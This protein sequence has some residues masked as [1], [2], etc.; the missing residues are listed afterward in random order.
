MKFNDQKNYFAHLKNA[1]KKEVNL[2]LIVVADDYERSQMIQFS[3]QFFLGDNFEC[4]R[5]DAMDTSYLKISQEADSISLF[6]NSSLIVIDNI[7]KLKDLAKFTHFV[8]KFKNTY[9]LLA[10]PSIKGIELL[11]KKVAKYGIVLNLSKEKP[12]DRNARIEKMLFL[13]AKKK[14]INL[15]QNAHEELIKRVGHNFALLDQELNKLI[16]FKYDTKEIKVEDVKQIVEGVSEVSI[17]QLAEQL[18]FEKKYPSNLVIDISSTNQFISALRYQLQQGFKM[19]SHLK[20]EITS[21]KLK[22][23]FPKLWPKQFEMRKSQVQKLSFSYFQNGLS[24]LHDIELN[25]RDSKSS[26]NA[27]LTLFIARLCHERC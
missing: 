1:F 22:E 2:H 20:E 25:L 5:L 4:I 16:L 12:W 7:Q 18:V 13:K 17:W 21:T 23:Y 15:N 10:A 19:A 26:L 9:F 11:E 27:N 6:S 14:G 24:H 8:E 3:K